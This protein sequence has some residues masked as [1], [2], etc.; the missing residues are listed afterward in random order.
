[1]SRARTKDDL[2]LSSQVFYDK[3]QHQIRSMPAACRRSVFS[4]EDR[5]RNLRDVIANLAGWQE[6]M[7]QFY[8]NGVIKGNFPEFPAPGYNWGSFPEFN[9]KIWRDCQKL[10]LQEA[11]DDLAYTHRLMIK[12]INQCSEPELFEVGT[13]RWTRNTDLAFY[14]DFVTCSNY[15]MATRKI[16]R[17]VGQ[18]KKQNPR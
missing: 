12:R 3:L 10:S 14:F 9:Q 15:Q 17:H 6:K 11:L 2:L 18:C 1:M 16:V 5:D 7:D 8:R 13:F 4:F